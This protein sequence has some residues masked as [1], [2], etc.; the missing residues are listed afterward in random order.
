M[1]DATEVQGSTAIPQ[2]FEVLPSPAASSPKPEDASC[3][4]AFLRGSTTSQ[5]RLSAVPTSD[6]CWTRKTTQVLLSLLCQERG[7]GSCRQ[8]QEGQAAQ[9]TAQEQY[10]RCCNTM[11]ILMP[12][13]FV[14]I[15][16]SINIL[17]ITCLH[18][19]NRKDKQTLGWIKFSNWRFPW[20]WSSS[21]AAFTEGKQIKTNIL[22]PKQDFTVHLDPYNTQNSQQTNIREAENNFPQEGKDLLFSDGF[23][24]GTVTP[25]IQPMG[26]HLNPR[27][28]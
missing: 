15:K 17:L 13:H 9:S 3:F 11:V 20:Q 2:L 18:C 14:M 16:L 22:I 19:S 5:Q 28:R 4:T 27:Y 24:E 23:P 8:E 7:R 26:L 12:N 10:H 25:Q 21:S 1:A 6:D